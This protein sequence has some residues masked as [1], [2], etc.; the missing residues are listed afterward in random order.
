MSLATLLTTLRGDPRFMA[1]VA[2]WQ[3][4]QLGQAQASDHLAAQL[5]VVELTL[6]GE[7]QRQRWVLLL[8]QQQYY[9][10]GAAGYY[11]LTAEQVTQL[12][13]PALR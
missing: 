6:S 12:C 1:N 3:T 11:P 9:L 8:D 4:L 2:A 10:Q 5:C 13:P 7:Q